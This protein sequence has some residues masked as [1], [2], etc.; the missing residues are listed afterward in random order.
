MTINHD[1]LRTMLLAITAIGIA[2]CGSENKEAA[3]E[4]PPTAAAIQDE[5]AEMAE[6]M[7]DETA[8]M[9]ETMK[10]EANDAIAEAEAAVDEAAGTV[11]SMIDGAG[12]GAMADDGDPCTLTIT[13]G[14]TI[15]FNTTQMSV[16]SSCDNVTVTLRHTGKLPAA[17]MGHNWVLV[18]ADAAD[19]VGMAG[20]S[21]GL[22]GNYLPAGDDRIV[23]ATDGMGGG[24]SDSVTFALADL[25]DGI[26]YVYVCTFPGHWSVM[27]GTFDVTS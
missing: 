3:G 26:D 20:M 18:P 2:A 4:A 9:A 11:D 7:K 14:D 17:A 5:A 6:S 13:A 23:A 22:E 12:S 27:K 24:E 8:D 21:A 19:A 10:K 25:A 16:P 15:A 1:Y